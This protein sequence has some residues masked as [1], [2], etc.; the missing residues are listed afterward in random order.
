MTMFIFLPSFVLI[1]RGVGLLFMTSLLLMLLTTVHFLIGAFGE[2]LSCKV[3]SL[4]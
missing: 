2:E 1:L 3:P 4:T